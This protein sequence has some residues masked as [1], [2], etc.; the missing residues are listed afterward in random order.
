M[1]IVVVGA[2]GLLGSDF[3]RLLAP[4]VDVV[5]LALADV[6]VTDREGVKQALA[7]ASPDV[8]LNCAGY[9]AV[10]QAES[11]PDIAYQVNVLGARNVAQAAERIGA[12]VIFFST[13][14]V[15]DGAATEPYVED[16]ATGPR[17]VY[18]RTKLLGEQ[19][20][21]EANPDHLIVRLAWLYGG[22]GH[23][24]VRTILR[25]ARE[26]DILRV[27]NDQTGSPTFTEDI[28]HQI[29]TLVTDGA[30]GTYHCV[31]TGSATWYDFARMI[32]HMTGSNTPIVPIQ[33]SDYS[34]AACRPVFSV[35]ADRNLDL[36]GL[37]VMRPWQEALDDCLSRYREDLLHV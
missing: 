25:L 10:D 9:T 19:A 29:L 35:L 34:A 22:S 15:F 2:D 11:E 7:S 26:K 14:Y 31:N 8:I 24:F 5:P 12:R 6:D 18:G 27:T 16:A 28:V 13:D 4:T 17:N 23:H 37:N 21:R 32:L 30:S 36:D 3:V 1:T 20:T 33:S